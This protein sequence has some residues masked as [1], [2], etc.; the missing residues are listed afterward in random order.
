MNKPIKDFKQ[1]VQKKMGLDSEAY[2]KA[3]SLTKQIE[4]SKYTSMSAKSWFEEEKLDDDDI[5]HVIVAAAYIT[6]QCHL[7]CDLAE[8]LAPLKPDQRKLVI[9]N[10]MKDA[11]K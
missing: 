8:I 10:A 1:Q 4:I 9:K 2:A 11:G 7:L 3:V 5:D 6:N